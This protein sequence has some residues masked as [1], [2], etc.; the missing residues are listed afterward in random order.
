MSSSQKISQA[1]AQGMEKGLLFID[2]N[3]GLM[4][5]LNNPLGDFLYQQ[6]RTS[7]LGNYTN[8]LSVAI[9][10]LMFLLTVSMSYLIFTSPSIVGHGEREREISSSSNKN[11]NKKKQ[12]QQQKSP[13]Q[14]SVQNKKQP[15][16]K[17]SPNKLPSQETPTKLAPIESV[18]SLFPSPS[19]GASS[20]SS[21]TTP[22][23]KAP[24]RKKASEKTPKKEMS[25]MMRDL[26]APNSSR[27]IVPPDRYKDVFQNG[28]DNYAVIRHLTRCRLHDVISIASTPKIR[29][30]KM[31]W[32]FD[33]DN[34]FSYQTV[35][36]VKIRDKRLGILHLLFITGIVIYIVLGTIFF[37]KRY[38]ATEAPIG[39]IRSSLLAPT[40]RDPT[41]PYCTSSGNTTYNGFPTMPC[42]YWDET[43]TLYP[44]VAD[45][46]MFISTRV[47]SENQI[48]NCSLT[49]PNCT[50]NITN[51]DT[52]YI[53]DVVNF[54]I[55][56]DHTL[57][58][59]ALGI[60][61]NAR[62]L[63]GILLNHDGD[64]WTP[65]PPSVVGVEGQYDILTLGVV[66]EA[67]GISSLDD[68]VISDTKY[69]AIEP[70]YTTDVNHRVVF[71]RHGVKIIFIQT[72]TLG[73]FDFQT[74]LLTFV[75]GIGLVTVST[76]I[77]D[78]L[79]VKLLPQ[80]EKY[81]QLKYQEAAVGV[82]LLHD[83]NHITNTTDE[84]DV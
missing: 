64:A 35:K 55:L 11:I 34:I 65:P 23:K 70:I 20:S 74:M 79:A 39:S 52:F 63:P 46:S 7:P 77:V 33:W 37:Q 82:P 60:Q 16:T 15:A 66:L 21:T 5:G 19:K 57:S 17:A 18:A 43:L 56:F 2:N 67:A 76:L 30:R 81:Q 6:L 44:S 61:Y 3:H 32:N 51:P 68:P 80:K 1:A 9:I 58:A 47:T 38:L 62:Q 72:G 26:P 53:A 4:S 13:K 27:K 22:T 40:Y 69:K 36:I 25:S 28:T 75:S 14:T 84:E 59:P 49:L 45:E 73:V 78:V 31:A 10:T 12:Q 54:T 71:N 83:G 8:F 24:G 48:A 41:P 42:Q 29:D 50:Y